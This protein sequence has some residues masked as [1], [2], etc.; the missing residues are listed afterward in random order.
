MEN[1]NLYNTDKTDSYK[2]CAICKEEKERK[3]F[4][5]NRKSLDGLKC[6]CNICDKKI[7][8]K[9]RNENTIEHRISSRNS[10]ILRR[11]DLGKTPKQLGLDRKSLREIS[12]ELKKLYEDLPNYDNFQIHH[13]ISWQQ[14]DFDNPLDI[15][16]FFSKY[17]YTILPKKQ[18]IRNHKRLI[19]NK[20]KVEEIKKEF[21]KIILTENN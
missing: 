16:L 10:N 4:Y 1:L 18:H 14:I 11:L 5:K 20:E 17:N 9:W 15:A 12:Q 7:Q 8:K 21:F 2:R 19:L 13:I 3:Y 6:Y